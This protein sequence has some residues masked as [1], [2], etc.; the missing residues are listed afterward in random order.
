MYA[1][2][3]QGQQH[4]QELKVAQHVREQYLAG[5][6]P[7]MKIWASTLDTITIHGLDWENLLSTLQTPD[8]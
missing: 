6:N 8:A 5:G 1:A 7:N 4:R 2:T 3:Y